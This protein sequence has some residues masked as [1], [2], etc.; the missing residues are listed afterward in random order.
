MLE[1]CENFRHCKIEYKVMNEKLKFWK[2][3]NL[4]IYKFCRLAKTWELKRV[5]IE[6]MKIKTLKML[7]PW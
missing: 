3:R 6:A 7:K 1:F 4:K 2:F 5:G